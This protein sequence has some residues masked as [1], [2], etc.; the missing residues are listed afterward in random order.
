MFLN[1]VPVGILLKSNGL[2][3]DLNNCVS[4]INQPVVSPLANTLVTCGL[5]KQIEVIAI[6]PHSTV[7]HLK[8]PSFPS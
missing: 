3:A 4:S 1:S 8:F 6:F 2:P 7:H 5:S